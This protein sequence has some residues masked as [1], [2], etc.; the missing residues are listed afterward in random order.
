MT[1]IEIEDDKGNTLCYFRVKNTKRE[2][3]VT[4]LRYCVLAD[5]ESD[6]LFDTGESLLRIQQQK[7]R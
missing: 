2:D 5:V 6:Y 7:Q 4:D 1:I 3:I